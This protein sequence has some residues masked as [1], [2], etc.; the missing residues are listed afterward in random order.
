[1]LKK[2]NANDFGVT[3]FASKRKKRKKRSVRCCECCRISHLRAKEKAAPS[4]D[5]L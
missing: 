2:I 5:G 1:V 3:I 4:G